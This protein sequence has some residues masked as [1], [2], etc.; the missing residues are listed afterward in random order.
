MKKTFFHAAILFA[1]LFAVDSAA[2][3]PVTS[4]QPVNTSK[5]SS[6]INAVIAEADSSAQ[7]IKG[8][9]NRGQKTVRDIFA[10][11][12]SGVPNEAAVV[13]DGIE[14]EDDC[15]KNLVKAIQA[16]K[17][18]KKIETDYAEGIAT[19]KIMLRG[20]A[21]FDWWNE[22]PTTSTSPFK[23]KSKKDNTLLVEYKLNGGNSGQIASN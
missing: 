7:V 19:I 3:K 11:F 5:Q 1:G 4:S 18:V 12:G 2:Q 14:F 13:I 22:L 15:F 9:A 6:R 16:R 10:L 8:V 23:M 21:G 17:E 20:K